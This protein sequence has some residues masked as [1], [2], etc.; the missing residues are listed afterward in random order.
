MVLL[1]V[2]VQLC[3]QFVRLDCMGQ[4]LWHSQAVAC[5]PPCI[6]VVQTLSHVTNRSAVGSQLW[7]STAVAWLLQ[8]ASCPPAWYGIIVCMLL[9]ECLHMALLQEHTKALYFIHCIV[10]LCSVR[11]DMLVGWTLLWAKLLSP[12]HSSC[13]G[14][15]LSSALC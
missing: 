14:C 8:F 7:Y 2:T 9:C 11:Q 13:V 12:I 4:Q 1:G 6:I 10:D 15:E 3:R 5:L